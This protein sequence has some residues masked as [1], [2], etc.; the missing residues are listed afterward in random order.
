VANFID[1]RGIFCRFFV[2]VVGG[3]NVEAYN[4]KK[5]WSVLL[6]VTLCIAFTVPAVIAAEKKAEP[7]KA[8]AAPKAAEVTQAEL[9]QLLVQVLGLARFLPASPS[10][11]QCFGM[12]MNNGISPKDGWKPGDPVVK[13]DLAR[14]I[15]Q[16]MKKQGDIKHPDDPKEWIDYLK[17]Q[18]VPLDAVGETTS[19]VD[20]LSE[21][22]AVHV[23]SAQVDPLVKRHKFNPLDETQYGV[24]MAYVVRVLSRFEFLAGEFN[25]R[26]VTPD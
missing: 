6:V 21:P 15:V 8:K 9:A 2:R 5:M 24:D 25:P 1:G 23:A 16:A 22:V 26:P 14:V 10:D 19:Y 4:M 11:Q 12:L 13:A 20:P 17:A 3:L 7:A 18:G